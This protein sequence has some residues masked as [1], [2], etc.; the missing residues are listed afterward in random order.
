[1]IGTLDLFNFADSDS[2]SASL[3]RLKQ[4]F[5]PPN[6]HKALPIYI[7]K[8]FSQLITRIRQIHSA[9]PVVC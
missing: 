9:C 7:A 2:A 5:V 1:M 6:F 8:E 4:Q 3:V